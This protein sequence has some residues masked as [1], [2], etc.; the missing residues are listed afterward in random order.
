MRI[1]G[2]STGADGFD[3]EV[4]LSNF[5]TG[6]W[7]H[8]VAIWDFANNKFIVYQDGTE[9]IN[10]SA[11]W[12]QTTL[13]Y[14]SLYQEFGGLSAASVWFDGKIDEAGIWSKAL[15]ASE[16]TDLYNA[17]AGLQYE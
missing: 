17:S 10:A 15:T 5:S 8:I 12:T 6:T 3:D 13:S 11:T 1:G 2:R 4:N 9:I 16:V 14:T 7:Y